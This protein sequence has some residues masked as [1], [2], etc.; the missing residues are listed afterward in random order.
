VSRA[1]L[2]SRRNWRI[3]APPSCQISESSVC[4]RSRSSAA[5][6]ATVEPSD[7]VTAR[8]SRRADRAHQRRPWQQLVDRRGQTVTC[9]PV[10]GTCG[11][12]GATRCPR[13]VRRARGHRAAVWSRLTKNHSQLGNGGVVIGV[14]PGA[15]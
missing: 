4:T 14:V 15:E 12:Q 6:A 5:I 3:D 7:R 1:T 13:R 10:R 9:A 2:S 11:H 8:V